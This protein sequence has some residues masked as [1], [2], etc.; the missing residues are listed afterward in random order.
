MLPHRFA[1]EIEGV[2]YA[3]KERLALRDV[4]LQVSAGEVF[5]FLGPNGGGKT[6]LFRILSTLLTVQ[7][8][9][10][11]VAGF[12]L[13][14]QS[15]EVRRKIGVVFQS[16][17][18]DKKLTV[19]EN[20][21]H[22]ATLY[23]VSG[24]RLADR[25]AEMMELFG[26]ADRAGDRA[27]F[28]S[29]GLRRRVELAK[30]LIHEPPILLL[31]EPTVGL[32][33]GARS[34]LWRCLLDLRKRRG[35]TVILTT[36]LLDEADRADRLAILD[37]GGLVAL[38]TPEK[39]RASIGGDTLLLRSTSP[40]RLLRELQERFGLTGRAIDGEVHIEVADG[41]R[42]V[43]RLYEACGELITGVTIG[44]PTL[45][46]VFIART[47]HRFRAESNG[48]GNPVRQ[49]SSHS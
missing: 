24:Q 36:H 40:D 13:P 9:S 7:R 16:P 3:Y 23:G 17:S 44:K 29:G 6:T 12:E 42:W 14:R 2:S 21:R 49:G 10:V 33:P 8:G 32:D 28:L 34:D 1:I 37:Q 27:E 18:L 15:S 45:E 31:D 47:G 38:D 46:D 26:I 20:I 30:G 5:A 39:L 35:T 22:Q 19:R 25:E 4:S 11:R 43:A 48:G 41:Y